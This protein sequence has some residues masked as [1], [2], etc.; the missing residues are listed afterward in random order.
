MAEVTKDQIVF[1][2]SNPL[3]K[4]FQNTPAPQARSKG[5]FIEALRNEYEPAQV[6]ITSA[7]YQGPVSV[8]VSPLVH[9]SGK[10]KISD[11]NARF[12]GYIPTPKVVPGSKKFPFL[13]SPSAYPDPLILD[14]E[15]I[16]KPKQTQPVWLTIKVPKDAM[17]GK[18]KGNI[19]VIT[20]K[21][22]SAL[23]L[24]LTVY[25]V[26]LPEKSIFNLGTWGGDTKLAELFE[27]VPRGKWQKGEYTSEYIDYIKNI[28]I[29]NRKEHRAKVFS[30][31]PLW[32]GMNLTKVYWK[33]GKYVYDYTLFD[34]FISTIEEG[35]KPIPFRTIGISVV[36]AS[37]KSNGGTIDEKKGEFNSKIV[38]LNPDG[39]LNSEKSVS[40]IS[41]DDPRY[42]AFIGNYFKAMSKHLKEKGWL[43]K[44]YFKILDE[45]TD[46]LIDPV[47]RLNAYIKKTAPEILLDATF[48]K[49]ASAVTMAKADYIN[50]L[51][52][53][54]WT[55]RVT[56]KLPQLIQDEASKGRDFWLYNDPKVTID[57]PLIQ[58]RTVGWQCYFYGAKGYMHWAYCWKDNPWENAF[59]KNWGFGAHFLVYPDMA[60]K[61]IVDSIRWEMLRE[62]AEDY[63][64]LYLLK[65]AGGNSKKYSK[66]VKD[67]SD[68]KQDPKLFYQIRHK[69]LVELNR[70][71]K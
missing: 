43:N 5:V 66:L 4:I 24:N 69:L 28:T 25:P 68:S 16:L 22:T 23:P 34:K 20:S 3:V 42:R 29:K 21:G 8:K 19:E 31:Q 13:D 59:D 54:S 50:L 38:V 1:W 37:V 35:F 12:V 7:G 49:P 61:K 30:D 11:V 27:I 6:C 52:P 44:V 67:L 41:T 36:Y 33:D 51:I 70:I 58:T 64:T 2:A 48:W 47:L 17:P 9:H 26:T 55:L 65:K 10:Y 71:A 14:E 53:T 39:S 60:R 15:V 63:D 32:A 62:T 40:C 56:P 45:P 57:K 46:A 18:Y